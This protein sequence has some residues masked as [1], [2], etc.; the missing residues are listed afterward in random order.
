MNANF[1]PDA[2]RRYQAS[3]GDPI[4]NS[5][6]SFEATYRAKIN[7]YLTL[8]PDVQYIAHTG[9]STTLRNPVVLGMHFEIGHVFDW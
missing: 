6:L 1:A 5:E 8:Q 7:D 9:Y 2:W 4:G 3:L